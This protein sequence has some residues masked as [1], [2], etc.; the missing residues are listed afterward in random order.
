MAKVFV[1]NEFPDIAQTLSESV[2]FGE[3]N[4]TGEMKSTNFGVIGNLGI[5]YQHNRHSFFLEAG[6]NYGFIN[7]QNDDTNGSNRL[8]AVSV[9]LGYAVALF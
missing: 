2:T 3:T 5:R 8:G 4:I 6:G 7:V 9:M 1:A